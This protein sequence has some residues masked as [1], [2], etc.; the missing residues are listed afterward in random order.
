[1]QPTVG[2]GCRESALNHANYLQ[3]CLAI[4][5]SGQELFLLHDAVQRPS[6]RAIHARSATCT[7][8]YLQNMYSIVIWEVPAAST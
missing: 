7:L 5:V 2:A 8:L 4:P 1:M 6:Q 3:K